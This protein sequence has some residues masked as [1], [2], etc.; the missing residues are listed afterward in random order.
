MSDI[1]IA[2]ATYSDVP[3]I[4]VPKVGGGFAEYTEGGGSASLTPFVLR[5]DA[6]LVQRWTYDKLIVAD[7]GIALPAYSTSSKTLKSSENLDEFTLSHSDY[8]Y[9][10]NA[11]CMSYPIYGSGAIA[12]G[13][14]EFGL[15]VFGYEFTHVPV[16]AAAS[17]SDPTVYTDNGVLFRADKKINAMLYWRSNSAISFY[18]TTGST[19]GALQDLSISTPSSTGKLKMKTPSLQLRGSGTYF[20]SDAWALMTDI[21]YQYILELWRAP[22]SNLNVDGW[23][24]EQSIMHG[25]DCWNNGGTLT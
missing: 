2:G 5:P 15:S 17:K 8:S 10:I 14:L 7:E 22:R 20:A 21:R 23:E 19:Y 11:R 1:T 18:M 24:I 4:L 16:R 12:Y 9:Y 3:S 13:R 6:E 25:I